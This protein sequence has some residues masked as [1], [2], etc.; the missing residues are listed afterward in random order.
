MKNNPSTSPAMGG[1]GNISN[2]NRDGV[3]AASLDR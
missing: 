2:M 3:V 1:M